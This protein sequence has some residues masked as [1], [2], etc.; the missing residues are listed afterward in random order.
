MSDIPAQRLLEQLRRTELEQV[1]AHF[2]PGARV[3]D[4][5]GGSGFQAAII[6]S[7][8]CDVSSIDIAGRPPEPKRYFDVIDYDGTTIPFAD[9]TFDVVFSSN[10]LEHVAHLPRL[11]GELRRVMKPA[12]TAIHVLPSPAWRF[13]T[14]VTHYPFL[15]KVALGLQQLPGSAPG[16]DTS[17]AVQQMGMGTAV[18]RALYPNAHG[19]YPGALAE[20]YYFAARRWRRVFEKH[21]FAVIERR[22]NELFCTGHTV[23]PGMSI[24][25]RHKL[26]RSLGS[27]CNIFFL[28]V[29]P[30]A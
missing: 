28:H 2:V 21:G 9:A 20:L 1:R 12:G 5:G 22:S 29:G 16:A 25:Q 3:L 19:E 24:E 17:A 27:S 23:L 13:W 11:L 18:R 7:W 26:A 6:A 30:D 4:F 14:I 15:V 8:G 10:V